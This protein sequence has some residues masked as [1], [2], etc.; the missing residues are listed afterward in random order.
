MTIQT[1]VENQARSWLKQLFAEDNGN[2]LCIAK[3]MAAVAF[4]SY[5]IYAGIGMWQHHFNLT[6]F[7][8]GLMTVLLGSA[9]VI[10]GKNFSTRD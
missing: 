5:L 1:D 3:I 2:D 4:V 6:D 7:G 8:T 9:G 10:A